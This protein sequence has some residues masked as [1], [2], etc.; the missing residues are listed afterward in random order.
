MERRVVV[1]D[2]RTSLEYISATSAG[3]MQPLTLGEWDAMDRNEI[4]HIWDA[5]SVV[6]EVRSEQETEELEEMTGPPKRDLSTMDVED[7]LA[8]LMR[9]GME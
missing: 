5:W 3:L 9:T 1:S 2:Y 7:T 4:D 8:E 6:Q